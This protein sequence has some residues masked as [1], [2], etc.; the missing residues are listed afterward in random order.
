MCR[1]S[2]K[3][4]R[5]SG[6]TAFKP[7][8]AR[9]REDYYESIRQ[10]FNAIEGLAPDERL[11]VDFAAGCSGLADV[12]ATVERHVNG[13]RLTTRD[14]IAQIAFFLS[15]TVYKWPAPQIL[16]WIK[17][18]EEALGQGAVASP[19]LDDRGMGNRV[20]HFRPITG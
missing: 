17:R 15:D 4:P 2:R 20:R 19:F 7:V 10:R 3:R 12:W 18:H 14:E 8:I 11:A 5:R 13:L 16:S 9:N 1:R 6:S